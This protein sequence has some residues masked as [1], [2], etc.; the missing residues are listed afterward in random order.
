MLTAHGYGSLA[1]AIELTIFNN[2]QRSRIGTGFGLITKD[3]IKQYN[4]K[5]PEGTG[6]QGH[7]GPGLK[8]M[9]KRPF[10]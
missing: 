10:I 3:H 1:G 9:Y 7:P 2:C 4:T 5:H 6:E 8:D